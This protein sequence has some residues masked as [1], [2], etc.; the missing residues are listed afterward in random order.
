MSASLRPFPIA[1]ALLALASACAT[2]HHD[3][4]QRS[5]QEPGPVAGGGDGEEAAA[6][7][8]PYE[9]PTAAGPPPEHRRESKLDR[10][11]TGFGLEFGM[12]GGGDDLVAA[13]YADGHQAKM[14]AGGLL[15]LAL[16]AEWTPVRTHQHHGFG[17]GVSGGVKYNGLS[18]NNGSVK[19]LRYPVI[20]SAHALWHVK[21]KYF[22]LTR[23]GVEKDLA[24]ALSGD[25]VGVG[26]NASFTSNLGVLGEVGVYWQADRDLGF[27]V[28]LRYTRIEYGYG[29]G[30][31][32]GSSI[33]LLVTALTTL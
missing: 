12:G 20:A 11:G 29:S 8:V 33:A 15:L 16:H 6:E 14:S 32:D 13:T 23:A 24:P 4:A 10:A 9:T 21:Q 26:V 17:V 22:F 31:I 5:R 2:A 28:K 19:F 7:P 27:D 30:S 1:T 25:G 3:G 18:G